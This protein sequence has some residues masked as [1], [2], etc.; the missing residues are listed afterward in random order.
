MIAGDK[1]VAVYP[2]LV[3]HRLSAPDFVQANAAAE[4]APK[5]LFGRDKLSW[6]IGSRPNI[7]TRLERRERPRKFEEA[8]GVKGGALDE[9][10]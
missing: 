5:V 4:K 8:Q 7:A 10:K 2:S 9:R 3:R 6:P 1:D